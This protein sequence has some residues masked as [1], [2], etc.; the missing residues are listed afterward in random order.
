M[1]KLEKRRSEGQEKKKVLS[2]W[3]KSC[4]IHRKNS[5]QWQI[6][7]TNLP[8]ET[9]FDKTKGRVYETWFSGRSSK[10]I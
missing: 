5:I 7:Q 3:D 10:F 6:H 8:N 4:L 9:R 2:C 1:Q